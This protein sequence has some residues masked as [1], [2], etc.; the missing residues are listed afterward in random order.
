M[1]ATLNIEYP[2]KK[3]PKFSSAQISKNGQIE[4]HPPSQYCGGGCAF[5]CF[6]SDV[7]VVDLCKATVGG[8][9]IFFVH[10]LAGPVHGGDNLVKRDL[11]GC[12]Q[13]AGEIDRADGTHG[14]D[15]V[16]L[17]TGDLHQAVHRVA[18][19]TEVVRHGDL[20]RV[21]DLVDVQT[22][23]GGERR[24]RHGT[25]A[26]D[27]RLAAAFR[28]GDAGVGADYVPDDSG[29][30]QSVDDLVLREAPVMLHVVQHRGQ[31]TAAAAGRGGHHDVLVGVFLAD[32]VGIGR[33]YP[34]HR[35]VRAFVV[36]AL[37]VEQ[38]RLAGDAQSAGQNALG[39]QAAMNGIL[40]GLPD[41]FQVV[42]Q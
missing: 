6:G 23:K 17:D 41:G 21:L 30:S 29:D 28:A 27:F 33:D 7:A 8:L 10:V 5:L 4:K 34:V 32:G 15:G 19:E 36:A 11:A 3:K 9:A 16:S 26:S 31:D 22:V 35:D 18:G 24:S 38:L 39:V 40:H 2:E 25:G 42:D 14:R 13:E 20:R 37:P 1:E 12:K